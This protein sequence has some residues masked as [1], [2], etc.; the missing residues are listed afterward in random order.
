MPNTHAMPCPVQYHHH[1]LDSTSIPHTIPYR[2]V[3]YRTAPH[4][5]ASHRIASHRT[6]VRT[7]PY[8]TIPYPPYHAIPFR[9][10]LYSSELYC[11][12]PYHIIRYHTIAYN[13]MRTK[14]DAHDIRPVPTHLIRPH[15]A[16]QAVVL[17]VEI[18]RNMSRKMRHPISCVLTLLVVLMEAG[19]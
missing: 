14:Y 7:I 17:R 16:Q 13:T 2:T 19:R 12:M 18:G 11:T 10:V 15:S 8:H 4:H 5:S 9:A 6:T 3:P 1:M